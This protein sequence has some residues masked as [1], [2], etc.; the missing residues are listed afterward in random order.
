MLVSIA[1]VLAASLIMATPAA[2]QQ[3]PP[4]FL[5]PADPSCDL[6]KIDA[7][8]ADANDACPGFAQA[9]C[10]PPCALAMA[11]IA[12]GDC[13][14]TIAGIIDQS[15]QAQQ[16][17]NGLAETVQ[18][19]A[20]ACVLGNAPAEL[21]LAAATAQGCAGAGGAPAA[22]GGG[23]RRA[24]DGGEER[25]ENEALLAA[26]AAA[27]GSVCALADALLTTPSPPPPPPP[28]CEDDA[29]WTDSVYGVGGCDAIT[30]Y[31]YEQY[32]TRLADAS[33]VSASEAC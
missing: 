1:I 30:A 9:Q 24:Q 19:Q 11:P 28:P 33:G 13:R 2:A 20:E 3:Q 32:C 23:H 15:E 31:G 12:Y 4:P 6:S 25:V 26:F 10:P 27:D 5:Q 18:R 29:D 16:Q 17:P 14:R 21:A 8:F 22:A 7:L